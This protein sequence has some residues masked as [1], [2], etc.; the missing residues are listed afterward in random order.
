MDNKEK[1]YTRVNMDYMIKQKEVENLWTKLT[2]EMSQVHSLDEENADKRLIVE[3]K[4]SEEI[5]LELSTLADEWEKLLKN[6]A[7]HEK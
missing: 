7:E 2:N 6:L 5:K 4:E 1:S 3:I